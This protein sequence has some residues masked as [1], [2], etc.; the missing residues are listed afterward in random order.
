MG[1]YLNDWTDGKFAI[2]G[3]AAASLA[4]GAAVP[5]VAQSSHQQL[6]D[7]LL[8]AAQNLARSN[9]YASTHSRYNG[10]LNSN[11]TETVTLTLDAGTSYMI[12][13]QC[14]G[15]CSDLDLWLYDENGYE[16]DSDVLEDDVPVLE[17]T[18][19]RTAR[20]SIRAKMITC[21]VEPCFYGIGVYGR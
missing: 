13:G 15:D 18:P 11:Q 1:V 16:I 12:V 10:S 7:S 3:L 8:D 6:V 19:R 5:G 4:L 9:G 20:F 14:D 21:S 17:V 2:A